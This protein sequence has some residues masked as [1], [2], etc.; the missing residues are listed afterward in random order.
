MCTFATLTEVLLA[1]P[2]LREVVGYLFELL[3]L[4]ERPGS[5]IWQVGLHLIS[6]TA[7]PSTPAYSSP[8]CL[9]RDGEPVTAAILLQRDSGVVGGA[10]WIAKPSCVDRHPDELPP[11]DVIANFTLEQPLE[12]YIVID[13]LVSHYVEPITTTPGCQRGTR[14]VL[15]VDYTPLVAVLDAV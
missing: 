4:A 14:K 8:D 1:N 13:Q 10:N 5:Q 12:G 11:E 7:T 15:L 2:F 6:L 3:P 9:H